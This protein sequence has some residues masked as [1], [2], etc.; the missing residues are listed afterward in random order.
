MTC[1]HCFSRYDLICVFVTIY[2]TCRRLH[3]IRNQARCCTW[4]C[5]LI[6]IDQVTGIITIR[7]TYNLENW[8]IIMIHICLVIPDLRH[9]IE[10]YFTLKG[11]LSHTASHQY[12]IDVDP[13]GFA[14]REQ[15]HRHNANATI[16]MGSNLYYQTTYWSCSSHVMSY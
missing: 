16:V 13:T 4:R 6:H 9:D 8:L 15:S 7:V 3:N 11:R 1:L 5:S 14:T 2:S 12:L 10:M